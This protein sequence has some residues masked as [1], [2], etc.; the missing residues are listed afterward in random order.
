MKSINGKVEVLAPSGDYDSFIAACQNGADAVYMGLDKFNARAMAKNFDLNTYIDCINYAHIRGVKVYL[1]LNTLMYDDEIKEALELV[2]KLYSKGLDA[3]IL[4]D[5][6]LAM[7]IHRECPDLHMHASTQMSVY[8][9]SQVKFLESIGFK[10]VVLAR[11]LSISEIKYICENSNVE[12]EVFVHGALCVSFSGQCLLSS[13]I[14]NRSANRG[15]CAQPCRMK[16]TLCDTNGKEFV[17]NT[18]IMSKKDIFGLDYIGK[19]IEIGVASLKIEGRN[20]T[21]EY[22]AGV[23]STYRKYVDKYLNDNENF[24]IDKL[25]EEDL[26]QLFNRNGKSHGYLD[27]VKYKDS[28]TLL[29]PKNTGKLLGKVI[30]QKGIYVK[31]KLEEDINMH[32]GF[33]I[34]SDGK[35][36]SN[37]VTCIRDENY[38]IINKEAKKGDYVWIGDVGSKIKFGASVYKTSSDVL[39]KRYRKSYENNVQNIKRAIDINLYFKENKNVCFDVLKND[40]I[41]REIINKGTNY[42]PDI[43]SKKPLTREDVINNFSKTKDLPFC[44]NIQKLEL[45]DGLFVPV[46]KLNEIRK[47]IVE[48]I[49]STFN[50]DIDVTDKLNSLDNFLNEYINEF[51]NDKI[52]CKKEICNSLY[53]YS[54]DNSVDYINLYQKKFNKNLNRIYISIVDYY[55]YGKVIKEKY[56]GKVDVYINIPN[57]VGKNIDKYILDNLKN[58]LTDG[59]K[60]FLLGSLSYIDA[61]NSL[62]KEFSFDIIADYSLNIS[63][64]YSALFLKSIGFYVITPSYD[65]S[66]SDIEVMSKYVD[67]EIVNDFVTVMTSK[68]C[69]LGSFIEDRGENSVCRKPCSKNDYILKDGYGYKYNIVCDNIDCIMRIVKRT[70]NIDIKEYNISGLVSIRDSVIK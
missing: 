70:R 10:R 20:K 39:N 62:K 48:E 34:Y 14:G 43:A 16:Y 52:P 22:V 57:V 61:I 46:S 2:L 15:K 67:V 65:I 28:I 59:I 54:Y 1:T 64:I 5:I 45:D 56:I 37:I 17:K 38:N 33:E 24:S 41:K 60:G 26:L 19:L 23:T 11:E 32:D 47:K 25:D 9:L 18:Y 69:I 35:V 21:P 4:Q 7:L 50:I 30:N 6:G 44:I 29:S 12:I 40:N 53:V 51:K 27:G 3:V 8:S 13:T 42:V 66:I 63:N 55:K 58:F 49:T 68:Y 36:F 31:L